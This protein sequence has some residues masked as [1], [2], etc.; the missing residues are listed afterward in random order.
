MKQNK[1]IPIIIVII[2]IIKVICLIYFA[3]PYLTHDTTIT[4][5]EAML[6]IPAWDE[7]GLIL[8]LGLLPLIISNTT[9]FIIF[10][11]KIKMPL[12]LL[13]FIPS[14][15]CLCLVISYWIYSFI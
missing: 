11:E 12:R 14:F 7:A 8:T 4:N 13:F 9:I 2:N 6:V 1:I 15:I 3:I 5:P 10:K